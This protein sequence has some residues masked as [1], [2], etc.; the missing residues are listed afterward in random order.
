MFLGQCSIKHLRGSSS[1]LIAQGRL[2]ICMWR[3]HSKKTIKW[4]ISGWQHPII[5]SS[6]I[7]LH[8]QSPQWL[9]WTLWTGLL[10]V[11][12]VALVAVSIQDLSPGPQVTRNSI[13]RTPI[14]CSLTPTY[15]VHQSLPLQLNHL[16][17]LRWNTQFGST[18]S[19]SLWFLSLAISLACA[20][21]ATLLQQ[22]AHR[23][24]TITQQPWFSLQ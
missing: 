22:R 12:V 7:S 24:L 2:S 6:P 23:Y 15:P 14:G 21:L 18:Y 13:S 5:V 3:W 19:E 17:S 11:A 8:P 9:T 20:P 4:P 1:F 16:P 10:S